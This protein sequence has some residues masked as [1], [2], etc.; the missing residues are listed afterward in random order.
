MVSLQVAGIDQRR[1]LGYKKY[2][3][4]C[5]D[6]WQEM[7][8]NENRRRQDTL[9]LDISNLISS[10]RFESSSKN[11]RI[12]QT[13]TTAYRTRAGIVFGL[14]CLPQFAICTQPSASV[15]QRFHIRQ[16][17]TQPYVTP[18]AVSDVDANADSVRRRRKFWLRAIWVSIVGVIVPPLFGLVGTV[19]GMVGAFGQLSDTGDADPERRR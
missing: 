14:L 3:T 18:Q 4:I 19:I 12:I 16:K 15:R 10:N 17:M 6:I 8:L 5:G 9:T 7:R 13:S 11:R 1:Q 2:D